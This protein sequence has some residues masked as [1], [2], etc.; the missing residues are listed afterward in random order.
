MTYVTT[1][2]ISKKKKKYKPKVGRKRRN[3]LRTI[4][5]LPS[6]RFGFLFQKNSKTKINSSEASGY[7]SWLSI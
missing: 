6:Q 4:K 1:L 7:L 3:K 2:K 5:K